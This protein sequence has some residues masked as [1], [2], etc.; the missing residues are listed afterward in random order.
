MDSE[1]NA[2]YAVD[3]QFRDEEGG[4]H[5]LEFYLTGF[6]SPSLGRTGSISSTRGRRA[7]ARYRSGTV[8]S[9][10]RHQNF[11]L[12]SHEAKAWYCNLVSE[13]LQHTTLADS[14]EH[15]IRE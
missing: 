1:Q 2:A 7:R 15:G 13:W 12:C 14:M 3:E 5:R 9:Q 6:S 10:D 8:G 4:N 11:R